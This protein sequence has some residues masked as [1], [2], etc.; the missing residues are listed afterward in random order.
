MNRPPPANMAEFPIGVGIDTARY[1]HY[2]TFIRGHD[3]Q[4]A[5]PPLEMSE[6]PQ[7]Y[8]QLQQR[9]QRLLDNH[10]NAQLHVRLD[11][12]GQYGANLEA[13]LRQAPWPMTLSI[14]DPSR[15]A[16]YRKAHYPKRK[17]D[18][19]DSLCAAR[20]AVVERPGVT[21]ETPPQIQALSE[22]A[23]RLE[24]QVTQVTRL[25]NQWHNLLSRVF[26]ELAVHTQNLAAAWVVALLDKYPSPER[27]A[28]ARTTTLQT[29]P[30][31]TRTHAQQVQTLARDSIASFRGQVAEQLVREQ[32]RQ[33]RHA[34]AGEKRLLDML[35][36]AYRDLPQTNH[37][38]SIPGIGVATA[39]VLTAKMVCIE[40]FATPDNL[41]GYF[42]FFPEASQSGFNRQGK[43]YPP[44]TMRMSPKGNDLVRKH[45]WNAAMSAI[46]CNPAA[47]ALYRRLRQRGARGDVA[48]GHVARKLLHLVHAV[49]RTGQPFDRDHYPWQHTTGAD[50][51]E[52]SPS[53]EKAAGRTQEV[54]ANRSAVTAATPSVNESNRGAKGGP[55]EEPSAQPS[56]VQ[57]SSTQ[58]ARRGV[59][60]SRVR[61][62]VSIEQVLIHLGLLQQL[63]GPSRQRRGPCPLH[64]Q[65]NPRQRTFSVNLDR[66]VFQCF[67][68]GCQAAGNTLDLWAAVHRCTVAQ[69]AQQMASAFALDLTQPHDSGP[70]P[71]GEP[72]FPTTRS[73]PSPS[74]TPRSAKRQDHETQATKQSGHHPRP[75]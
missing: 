23:S 44:G 72:V 38:D 59:D 7:G 61:R 21:A 24:A 52:P 67:A 32:V 19:V 33:L 42:G 46:N 13:F 31:L 5:A 65:S 3:L 11:A 55:P 37:L 57:P 10:P 56:S 43:R 40:R 51:T 1:G 62:L 45:L 30:Y 48:L 35:E 41:V 58:P 12:A 22:I 73:S 49:W 50:S 4:P 14:G 18:D 39:A 60:I 26:P 63:R 68:P 47:R 34:R 71:S 15:N 2:V 16:N 53:T 28:R 8:Q 66:N 75:H 70:S 25:T 29:I 74:H 27:I 17:S 20:F 54:P 69:A 9:F 64:D 36:T 6:S